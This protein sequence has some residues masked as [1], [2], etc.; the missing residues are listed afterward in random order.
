MSVYL[1]ICHLCV[2]LCLSVHKCFCLS[3]YLFIYVRMYLYLPVCLSICLYLCW[4][5]YVFLFVFVKVIFYQFLYICI[6]LFMSMP[7]DLKYL[8][9]LFVCMPLLLVVIVWLCGHILR[10]LRAGLCTTTTT[11][12]ASLHY[13]CE[14]CFRPRHCKHVL[15]RTVSSADCREEK[16]VAY[17]SGVLLMLQVCGAST[18]ILIRLNLLLVFILIRLY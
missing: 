4:S 15:N 6:S 18:Q 3:T 14:Q 16:C 2:F 8:H 1:F 13:R 11:S 7:G 17:G 10:S 5:V 9:I 12:T